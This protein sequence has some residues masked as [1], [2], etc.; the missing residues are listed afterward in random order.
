M[1][2]RILFGDAP[3]SGTFSYRDP[4]PEELAGSFHLLVDSRP[5][6]WIVIKPRSGEM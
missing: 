5:G 6:M 2:S 1:M 3:H 4:T